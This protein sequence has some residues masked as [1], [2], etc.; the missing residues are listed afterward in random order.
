MA[1]SPSAELVKKPRSKRKPAGDGSELFWGPP[2]EF[3]LSSPAK[4]I[5]RSPS[6]G[7]PSLSSSKRNRLAIS[8]IS[9]HVLSEPTSA[10][11]R[12]DETEWLANSEFEETPLERHRYVSSR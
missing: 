7:A 8:M 2:E 6:T 9:P 11:Y 12:V 10:G 3:S 5:R 4:R 1:P